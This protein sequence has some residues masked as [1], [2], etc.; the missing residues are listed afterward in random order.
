MKTD[1]IDKV[2]FG[3]LKKMIEGEGMIKRIQYRK[4]VQKSLTGKKPAV[5]KG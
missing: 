2:D 1:Q 3:D 4:S 5:A